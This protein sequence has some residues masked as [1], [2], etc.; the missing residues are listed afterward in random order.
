MQEG[1]EARYLLEAVADT[2]TDNIGVQVQ[3][4]PYPV[5]ANVRIVVEVFEVGVQV[6]VVAE[7]DIRTGLR[8]PTDVGIDLCIRSNV[9]ALLE[10]NDPGCTNADIRADQRAGKR[11]ILD[12]ESRGKKPGGSYVVFRVHR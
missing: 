8:S 10:R 5:E 7:G 6:Q 12:G 9:D 11:M 3:F 4:V 1:E 2:K